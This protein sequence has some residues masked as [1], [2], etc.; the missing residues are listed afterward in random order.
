[1]RALSS[2]SVVTVAAA[3]FLLSAPA[4]HAH[5]DHG[6]EP[7]PAASASA[8]ANTSPDAGAELAETGSE[9]P[10]SAL[11]TAAASMLGAG[12]YVLLRRREVRA[13]HG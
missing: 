5:G 7:S 2:A 8:P 4:A 11:A 6:S 1:M 9:V 3:A 13:Q 12:V 10:A